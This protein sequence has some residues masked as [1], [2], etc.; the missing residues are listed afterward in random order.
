MLR[1]DR[2]K[3]PALSLALVAACEQ[4]TS[5]PS[6][7]PMVQGAAVIAGS[8]RTS[9]S[10]IDKLGEVAAS[11]RPC[12]GDAYGGIELVADVAPDA[13]DETILASYTRGI[14]VLGA[15][16]HR[17]AT[18][19]GFGCSGSQDELVALE[20]LRTSQD[21]PVIAAAVIQG[22]R[23]ESSTRIHL[24]AVDATKHLDPLFTGEV[25]HVDGAATLGGAITFVPGGLIY[26]HPTNGVTLWKFD[27]NL[28]RYV[29]PGLR[30]D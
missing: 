17:I 6:V 5:V 15:D 4:P 29:D 11:A 21:A 10:V 14:V 7:L 27:R 20:V 23:R 3:W 22:G 16:G 30:R 9:S 8:D 28:R 1:I 25:E 13:G 18:S 19:P 24:F 26:R 2:M 12:V